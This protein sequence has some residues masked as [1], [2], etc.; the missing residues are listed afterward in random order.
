MAA[1][2]ANFG[3]DRTTGGGAGGGWRAFL[4]LTA[5]SFCWEFLRRNRLYQDHFRDLVCGAT[6]LDR[7]WGL[8]APANPALSAD[9]ACVVW[10]ADVA[11]GLVVSMEPRSFAGPKALP[12]TSTDAIVG[13]DGCHLRLA[14]GLQVRVRDR[15]TAAGPLVVVL[16]YD[17]DFHLRIRAVEALRRATTTDSPPRSRFNADQRARLARTLFAL[18]AALQERSYRDIA[19]DL[20]GDATLNDVAFKTSSVRDVTIRL[21]RRGRALM[22][23]GYLKML[24]AGF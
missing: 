4:D 12:R 19:A 3:S 23:G 15:A 2:D 22:A 11:P 13:D 14:S 17:S 20:F 24:R 10:R 8:S 5:P 18:D 1:P 21:V 16:S 9:S 7:R 6:E